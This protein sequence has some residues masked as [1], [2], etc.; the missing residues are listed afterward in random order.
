MLLFS[1]GAWEHNDGPSR[2]RLAED[3]CRRCVLLVAQVTNPK[4]D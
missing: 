4:F 2:G 3:I 1:C